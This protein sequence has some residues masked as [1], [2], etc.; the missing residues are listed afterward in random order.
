[1]TTSNTNTTTLNSDNLNTFKALIGFGG[2]FLTADQV[3]E[4]VK[5]NPAAAF[6]GLVEVLARQTAD[7]RF[8]GGT[9]HK[10]KFG[11]SKRHVT[12]G[13]LL[14]NKF[15]N[16]LEL[17]VAEMEQACTIAYAYRSQLWMISLGAVPQNDLN[18]RPHLTPTAG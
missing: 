4:A 17:T 6:C 15:L 13:T 1:M 16:G 5:A 3:G 10:N 8:G 18:L 11:F 14:A 2:R 12:P 7:E 9:C